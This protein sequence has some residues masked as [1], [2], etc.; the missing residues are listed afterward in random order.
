MIGTAFSHCIVTRD[1]F[2]IR[3]G[4]FVG[5]ETWRRR[6]A[7]LLLYT[8]SYWE[9]ARAEVLT[10]KNDEGFTFIVNGVILVSIQDIRYSNDSRSCLSVDAR[11]KFWLHLDINLSARIDTRLRRL[12]VLFGW[13]EG[14]MR[15]GELG[16][17]SFAWN[18]R[19][20]KVVCWVY[21]G[22]FLAISGSGFWGRDVMIFLI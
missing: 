19:V 20:G 21:T 10:E 1:K 5:Q 22:V 11:V 17:Y 8:R 14:F 6:A 3:V 4:L 7:A 13:I 16:E 12:S 9:V 18:T 2:R 15:S